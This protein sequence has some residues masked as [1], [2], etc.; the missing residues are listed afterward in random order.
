MRA[1]VFEAPIPKYIATLV[2][3]RIS[4]SLYVGP[5]A[6]TRFEEIERPALPNDRWVRIRTSLGGVCGSD[7]AIIGLQTSPSTSPLSS[8]PF[9]LGHENV[10]IVTE[11]GS[12]A[13]GIAVGQRVTANPLL[14]C[15]P[16]AIEPVCAACA[17]GHHSRCTCFTDG[18]IPPGM[19]I[20]TTKSVG[21]S[22]GDEF[23]AHESQLVPLPDSLS[24]TAAL[25]TEPFACCVHAVR[26]TLPAEHDRTL[27][28]GGG[29][30]GLLTV[31]ALSALAPQS[32]TTILARHRFQG[33]HAQRLGASRTVLA[34]GDYM[35]ELADA[36]E[37][38]LLK[39]II[40]P[41]IGVGGFD[42]TFVCA[43]ND[44]AISDALR[45]TRS[46][47]RIVLLGNVATLKSVDWTPLWLKELR[48]TGSLAYG[49]HGHGGASLNAFN[50]AAQIIA[51]EQALFQPLVTHTFALNDFQKALSVAR[52]RS[53]EQSVKVALKP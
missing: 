29:T 49:A 1:V 25:L 27:V 3:G 2:A 40:G 50:E 22:W 34:R 11:V 12:R 5:H 39:P 38:R 36:A 14:C 37:T 41:P 33:D 31:A 30:M 52:S 19:F 28:I 43:S 42:V 17:G 53:G 18:M 13:R 26:S 23:V 4:D 51:R 16:R 32:R 44:R 47:G 20:G 45:F 48:I 8:F 46:G 35:K 24:D 10:G 9:V 15:E 6:C 21:G 7:L